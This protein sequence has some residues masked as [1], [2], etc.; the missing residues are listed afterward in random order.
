MSSC[1]NANGTKN[2][3][4]LELLTKLRQELQSIVQP[5]IQRNTYWLHPH[6]VLSV[7]AEE[8]PDVRA[9]AVQALQ[10]DAGYSRRHNLSGKLPGND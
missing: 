2:Q 4:S 1:I 8:N 6:S 10:V 5:V 9:R 3:R 7:V